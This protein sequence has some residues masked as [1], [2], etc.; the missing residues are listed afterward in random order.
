MLLK[1]RCR[2]YHNAM[3]MSKEI[4][5]KMGIDILDPV[6]GSRSGVYNVA[7]LAKAEEKSD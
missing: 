4:A 5:R 2:S 6:A 3:P 1:T 7:E